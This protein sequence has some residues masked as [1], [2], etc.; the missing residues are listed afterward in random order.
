MPLFSPR[1]HDFSAVENLGISIYEVSSDGEQR[2]VGFIYKVD[3]EAGVIY[4]HC[5]WH[6]PS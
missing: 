3:D 5:A 4:C 6:C 2:H 1:K